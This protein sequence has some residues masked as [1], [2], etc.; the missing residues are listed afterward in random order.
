VI[1]DPY[2]IPVQSD[3]GDAECIEAPKPLGDVFESVAGAIF[4]DSGLDIFEVWRVCY[5]MLEKF[6][7]EFYHP[8]HN[9]STVISRLPLI[10][11]T[12][13]STSALTSFFPQM[14]ILRMCPKVQ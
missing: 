14:N 9:T 4:L 10:T 1:P 8:Q 5:P 3:C 12:D 13:V 11:L 6:I 7:G 2:A